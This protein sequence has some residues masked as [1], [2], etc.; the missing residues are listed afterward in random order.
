MTAHPVPTGCCSAPPHRR[1]VGRGLS[2]LF[3]RNRKTGL[4]CEISRVLKTYNLCN[5]T[6]AHVCAHTLT[7]AETAHSEFFQ[8]LV[9]TGPSFYKLPNNLA[10]FSQCH[11]FPSMAFH[12][13]VPLSQISHI[14]FIHPQKEEI[15]RLSFQ[16]ASWG[17]RI[18]RD[19]NIQLFKLLPSDDPLLAFLIGD[20]V[21]SA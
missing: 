19:F 20:H 2:V 18:L 6:H 12:P 3:K 14:T 16:K 13:A 9:C 7:K 1:C 21:A 11:S 4:L 8:S 10:S 5:N 15:S 17:L